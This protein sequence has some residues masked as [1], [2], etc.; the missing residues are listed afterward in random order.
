MTRL[1]K[2]VRIPAALSL[3]LLTGA[4]GDLFEVTNP[5]PIQDELLNRQDAVPGL[6]VGMS[7]DLSAAINS[8]LALISIASDDLAHGGSYT[9]QG[10]WYRGIILEDGI[11]GQWAN[12]QRARWVAESGIERM[13]EILGDGYEADINS[14]R[15]N[16]LAGY[17]N[18]LL[19]ENVCDA[20]IDGGEKQAHTIHFSRGEAYF[21]EG[22]R[23]ATALNNTPLRNAAL[24]GRASMR[25]W[26]GNWADAAADAQQVP[27]NFRFD[28]TFSLNST[29]EYNDLVTETWVRFEYT[30]YNTPWAQIRGDPRVPWDTLKGPGGGV[31]NGQDGKTPFFQQKKY[32]D[33][34]SEVPLAKGTE[35]RIL[36][37]EAALRSNDLAGFTDRVNEARAFNNLTA[38][39]QPANA[40]DAWTILKRER[41]AIVWIEGRRLWDL[42]RWNA[43]GKDSFLTDRDKC[44]PISRNEIDSNPNLR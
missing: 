44:I 41:G 33:R 12:M 23:L 6:V 8:T 5:G 18:R 38:I 31:R 42:R 11:N 30:V 36:Q 35:M 9:E 43:E 13:K 1:A 34:G 22:L 10:L 24:A 40:D 19:G 28:A 2:L 26:Q 21:T 15:A 16:V 17:A 7:G 39:S 20:V 25:A 27:T 37:A 29:R 3:A 32:V 4:C 14:A